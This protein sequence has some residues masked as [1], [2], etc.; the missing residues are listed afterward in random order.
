M[1]MDQAN[2]LSD[3]LERYKG[4]FNALW[5]LPDAS[6]IN[7]AITQYLIDYSV[8]EKIPLIGFSE[9]MVKAGFLISLEGN[10]K[11][12]GTK[13]GETSV[14]VLRGEKPERVSYI[15]E[16]R[17]FV[18]RQIAAF[19]DIRIS[20]ALYALTQKVYPLE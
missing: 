13:T 3:N 7:S 6:L 8:K 2:R 17:T 9:K 14:M 5:I 4:Q 16:F 1:P 20:P 12:I 19:M 11:A 10:Y 15:S 18:N